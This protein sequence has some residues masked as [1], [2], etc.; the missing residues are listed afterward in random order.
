MQNNQDTSSGKSI[1]QLLDILSER[2]ENTQLGESFW[3]ANQDVASELADRLGVTPLQSV[4][5]SICLRHGPRNVDYNDF[6]RHLDISNIHALEYCGELNALIRARY[7]KF[8][9]AHHEDSFDVPRAVI[10]A[11]KNNAVP[12]SPAK[13]GLT[14]HNLFDRLDEMF[15]DLDDD[16]ISPG[17]L[18]HELKDLF[19]ANPQITFVRELAG[20]KITC[21]CD[22][23]I[24]VII[25][26]YLINKDDDRI[27]FSQIEDVF[28]HKCEFAEAKSAL[29][30]GRHTLMQ[31][32]LLEH[33]CED[34]IANTS[35]VRLTAKARQILLSEFHL[36]SDE[37]SVA[38]LTKPELLM[39][40][41][42]FFTDATGG[43]VEELRTFLTPERYQE[44]RKRMKENGLR[45][46][47]ACLFYG[48]P[49]TGKTE[50][51]Y[52]LARQTGRSI[53]SVNIPEI[54]SKWV[55]DSEKNIQ[56]VFERYRL[57]VQRSETAP[58]LVFNEADA[59]FGRRMEGATRSVDKMENSIQN[60]ILQEMESLDG[61]LIATTNLTR[62][63]DPAFERRFLYKIRFERP[64]A[65]V[66]GKIWQTMIPGLSAEECREL[67][68][69]YDL[70]GGQMENVSRKYTINE[71]LHGNEK[72]RM[73][74][75]RSYCDAEKMDGQVKSRRIGF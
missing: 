50:T 48:E 19:A 35:Q 9:D 55:G 20:L 32:G 38:G 17:D 21:Y 34:G 70:S 40:K 54:K 68:A 62:N 53:L 44:I 2:S 69:S 5:L 12:E 3:V 37:P 29:K 33:V 46:G 51:V 25:S 66:R 24:L 31:E 57:L 71:I 59:I 7:L 67:A 27:T 15:E 13:T 47:F 10:L 73:D 45:S 36:K 49:G 61:I 26:H 6:S 52:Q 63:L 1:L 58:I 74:V 30:E 23:M 18:Y 22:W 65:T 72:K 39:E 42:L 11:F 56:A 60:I 64:D 16:A 8:H 75:L 28:R 43:Q 14:V 4:L 41:K